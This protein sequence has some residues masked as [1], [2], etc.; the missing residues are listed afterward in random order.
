MARL[1]LRQMRTD[2]KVLLARIHHFQTGAL[3]SLWH[4][5]LRL[6]P[7]LSTSHSLFPFLFIYLSLSQQWKA[8]FDKVCSATVAWLS[9]HICMFNSLWSGVVFKGAHLC[10]N[11]LWP[12]TIAVIS[13][14]QD[15]CAKQMK[16]CTVPLKGHET[17]GRIWMD[18]DSVLHQKHNREQ[19]NWIK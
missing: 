14:N 11:C 17:W 16:H 10:V 19:E 13:L 6:F 9:Y 3:L 7:P 8:L 2:M 15:R 12:L 4:L 18:W 1:Q 5:F